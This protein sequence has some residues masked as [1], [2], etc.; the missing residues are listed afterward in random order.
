MPRAIAGSAPPPFTRHRLLLL[1][2]CLL[3]FIE[4]ERERNKSYNNM[5]LVLCFLAVVFHAVVMSS[6]D[7]G[8]QKRLVVHGYRWRESSVYSKKDMEH[9]SFVNREVDSSASFQKRVYLPHHEW[10]RPPVVFRKRAAGNIT[11]I[12]QWWRK[13][14]SVPSASGCPL[15]ALN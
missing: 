7:S 15:H 4:R 13:K 2:R 11:L 14:K 10:Y 5:R 1:P 12:I 3:F 6:R 8:F 9:S